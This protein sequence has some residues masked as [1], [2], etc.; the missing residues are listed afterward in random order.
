MGCITSGSKCFTLRTTNYKATG[1]ML[2]NVDCT[3]GAVDFNA[4]QSSAIYGA[5]DT[6]QPPAIFLIP[7]VKY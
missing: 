3:L 4:S 1:V 6:V 5:S 2:G 7:Q